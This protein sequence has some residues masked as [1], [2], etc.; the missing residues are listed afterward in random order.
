MNKL[1]LL[2]FLIG[3]GGG[4]DSQF[5]RLFALSPQDTT[6]SALTGT[7]GGEISGLEQRWVIRADRFTI[8]QRCGTTVIG[9]EAAAT[10]TPTKIQIREAKEAGSDKC[11]LATAVD[12]V[13]ACTPTFDKL[14]CFVH[15]ANKLHLHTATDTF[16]VLTKLAD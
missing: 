6:S 5:A 14:P 3:C 13:D 1:A 9:V 7:W 15:A 11:N 16:H 8:A 2:A 10:I 12:E 4:D